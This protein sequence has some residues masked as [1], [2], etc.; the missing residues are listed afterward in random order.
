MESKKIALIIPSYNNAKW[1][2]K[3]LFS[4]LAQKYDNWR[5]VYTDDKSPD[6]TG[7]LVK[8]MVQ[9]RKKTDLINVSINEDRVGALHNLYTMI[10]ECDDDEIVV[11]LDGDDWLMHGDVLSRVN[12]EYNK[13]DVWMTYGSYVDL[14]RNTR[15]CCKPYEPEVI[16]HN[17]FR[18]VPW[19]ASH[20]RTFYAKLFKQIK[21][22]D[23]QY[24]GKF[25]E[26]AWD[27]SFMLP[28]LEMSGTHFS[29]MK[30]ILYGY[31]NENPISDFRIK[32][33]QQAMFDG[34]IRRRPKYQPLGK[35]F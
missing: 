22:E 14:P 31:N 34:H 21:K 23:M 33:Q 19:R 6:G 17:R 9:D 30:D 18:N 8:K 3:N 5:V 32:Q 24:E 15:G 25:Y 20:L 16:N 13:K 2:Q 27:L 35:L 12:E 29:Y 4:V 10:H 28:M 11:T 7:E 26:S 1:Y